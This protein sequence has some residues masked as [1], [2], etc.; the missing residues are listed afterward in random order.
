MKDEESLKA[1]AVVGKTANFVHDSV[2][3]FFANGI[4]TTGICT[5]GKSSYH[6]DCGNNLT[7][8]G[9]IFLPCD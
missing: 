2:N 9:S 5:G 6:Y 4:V 8:V 1:T 7:V 3:L